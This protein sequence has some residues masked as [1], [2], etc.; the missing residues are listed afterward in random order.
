MNL[1]LIN[2]SYWSTMIPSEVEYRRNIC[3]IQ[4]FSNL[5]MQNYLQGNVKNEF[6]VIFHYLYSM[7]IFYI[8]NAFTSCLFIIK[9]PWMCRNR[10]RR[11]KLWILGDITVLYPKQATQHGLNALSWIRKIYTK[12]WI[13]QC[14][15]NGLAGIVIILAAEII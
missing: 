4:Y 10:E 6:F 15:N 11:Q 12:E 8:R 9:M 3:H 13:W 2:Q 14:P 7:H 5:N 1:L